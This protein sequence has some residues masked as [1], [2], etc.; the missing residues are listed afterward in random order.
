MKLDELLEKKPEVKKNTQE[1][2]EEY[3]SKKPNLM[4]RYAA[5]M[6]DLIM[7]AILIV[8]F[9][10]AGRY[11]I[12]DPMGHKDDVD[13]VHN[14]CAESSL[15]VEIGGGYYSVDPEGEGTYD[16]KKTAEENYEYRI[17]YYYTNF[18][19]PI[20]LNMTKTYFQEREATKYWSPIGEA[21]PYSLTKGATISEIETWMKAHY[22]R[23]AADLD[24]KVAG[25]LARQYSIATST[26]SS[27]PEYIQHVR[28]ATLTEYFVVLIA[29]VLA[30]GIYYILFP[31]VLKR[32]ATPFKLVF[33]IAVA[34]KNEPK[35][36]SK[37]QILLRYILLVA[38]NILLPTVWYFFMPPS[39]GYLALMFPMI[40]ILILGTSF[41]NCGI[42][43]FAAQ[44]YLADFKDHR[45]VLKGEETLLGT[46][47]KSKVDPKAKP[48]VAK[49][50]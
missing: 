5:A 28:H 23:S 12:L 42:H 43:D 2:K 24:T 4:T 26:L 32:G 35:I 8:G 9:F 49:K 37:S 11:T 18:D 45:L 33:K 7:A 3:P 25:W 22:Q 13:F 21:E 17:L 31:L 40:E 44:T 41:N 34:D 50:K 15:Y 20:K 19:H 29:E 10:F 6:L 47:N 30:A 39:I 1:V 36:A 48:Q 46:P 38:I 14:A 16:S 27:T